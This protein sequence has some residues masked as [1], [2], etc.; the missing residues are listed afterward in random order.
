MPQMKYH[1][2]QRSPQRWFQILFCTG[3]GSVEAEQLN[4]PNQAAATGMAELSRQGERALRTR[5]DSVTI[6][7]RI[8]YQVL[9]LFLGCQVTEPH[10]L[11]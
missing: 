9:S 3:C 8:K 7:T 5:L 10:K 11:F 4:I 2:T 1:P 6:K